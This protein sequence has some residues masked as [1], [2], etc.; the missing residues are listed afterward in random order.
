MAR[1]SLLGWVKT[2]VLA[3]ALAVGTDAASAQYQR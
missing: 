2:L 3:G 1:K